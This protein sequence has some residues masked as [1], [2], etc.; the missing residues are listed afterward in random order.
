MSCKTMYYSLVELRF[1]CMYVCLCGGEGSA[2]AELRVEEGVGVM[3]SMNG[4]RHPYRLSDLIVACKILN[5]PFSISSYCI[6]CP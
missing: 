6:S 4:L 1:M 5:L 3:N 2:W